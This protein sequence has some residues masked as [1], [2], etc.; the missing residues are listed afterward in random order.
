MSRTLRVLLL[1]DTHLGFDLP[2][3]PRV[4]RR[5]RG[6]D[7]F[8]NFQRALEPA[9]RREVDLVVH[10]GDVLYRSKVR[11]QLV[12]KAFAPL[13]RVADGGV[14]VV[15]VPGNHER[16]NIPFP[17]LAT[18][19][20][21]HIL[22]RPRTLS[23]EIAGLTVSLV[24]FPNERRDVRGRFR[25]LLAETRWQERASDVRLL[26]IHQ[27]VEGARVGPSGYTFRDGADVIRGS[28]VPVGFA[29]VLAGHIHRHQVLTA[30]LAGRPLAAPVLYPGSIERTSAAERHEA[31]GFL[32]LELSP[33]AAGGQ[34]RSWSFHRLPARPM[35]DI[36]LDP[37]GLGGEQL[38]ARV[39]ELLAGVDPDAVVRLCLRAE[40][41]PEAR[42]ALQAAV[43]RSHAP[44]SMTLTIRWP[45]TAVADAAWRHH[46]SAD[47]AMGRSASARSPAARASAP[48]CR[49]F[50]GQEV[51]AALGRPAGG[52]A[53]ELLSAAHE[54][55][56][57][58]PEQRFLAL[59]AL[60]GERLEGGSGPLRQHDGLLDGRRIVG[61]QEVVEDRGETTPNRPGSPRPRASTSR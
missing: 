7:F 55:F 38:E 9:L 40:P 33:T 15:V 5:R 3:R 39:R 8:A 50:R 27:A 51:P 16:S 47:V 35:V 32:I 59:A 21:I 20:A 13:M 30:D 22:N 28:D 11:P 17:L 57:G 43:L 54:D 12:E 58:F 26:C 23:L 61:G 10:G 46:E 29:A 41:A 2:L 6:P 4:E 19:P 1:A 31:K 42:G 45:G 53:V 37:S 36:D 18:H 25:Q 24:G 44:P 34:L 52:S 14:P 48:C 56:E 60:V 49:S